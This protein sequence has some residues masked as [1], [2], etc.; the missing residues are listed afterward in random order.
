VVRDIGAEQCGIVTFTV[1]GINAQSVQQALAP[2]AINVTISTA[3]STL[4]DMEA[5]GLREV[6][7]ASVHYYNDD[8]EID[9]FCDAVESRKS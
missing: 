6:V 4:F 8:A 7:R 2:Q 5:R 3:S 9:R 1:A